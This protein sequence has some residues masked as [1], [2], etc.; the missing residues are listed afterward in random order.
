MNILLVIYQNPFKSKYK[1]SQKL[2]GE[3]GIFICL[4]F[5][6]LFSLN[7]MVLI[8]IN[9]K[10]T[11]IDRGRRIEVRLVNYWSDLFCDCF[12]VY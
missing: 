9:C 6:I 3:V 1:T 10:G 11:F 2:V 7:D 12:L 8:I 5:T 4:G